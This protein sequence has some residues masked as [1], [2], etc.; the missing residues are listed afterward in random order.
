MIC[1]VSRSENGGM[2]GPAKWKLPA[3]FHEQAI[4]TLL[5]RAAICREIG[6]PVI[7]A[8]DPADAK[9]EMPEQAGAM[10]GGILSRAGATQR[11]GPGS[12]YPDTL[13]FIKG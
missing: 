5:A 3:S 11:S 1:L 9:R 13:R 10:R 4:M 7:V 6:N 12:R 2:A 8:A